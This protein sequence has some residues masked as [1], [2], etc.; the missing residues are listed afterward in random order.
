LDMVTQGTTMYVRVPSQVSSSLPLN[1][2]QWI[3]VDIGRLSGLSGLSSLQGNPLASDPGRILQYL[4]AESSSVVNA[5]AQVV[6]GVDTTHYRAELDLDH[7]GD[8]LP[9]AARS[10]AQQLF[11][12]YEALAHSSTMPVE[13]WIDA[14]HLVRR[15]AL[16]L[17]LG[18]PTG[19]SL[20]EAM[21]VDLMH[22]GPQVTPTPPPSGEVQDLSGLLSGSGL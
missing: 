6:G 14:R 13:V 12:Q 8:A 11:K 9:S 15:I 5:G 19:Q 20:T 2:K 7:V 22:Y 10:A 17:S 4:R 3:K 21:T 18:L 1:G 16:N